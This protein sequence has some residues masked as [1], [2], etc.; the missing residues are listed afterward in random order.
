MSP[1]QQL[2]QILEGGFD[3]VVDTGVRALQSNH[4]QSDWQ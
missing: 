2:N 3:S 1:K 4:L